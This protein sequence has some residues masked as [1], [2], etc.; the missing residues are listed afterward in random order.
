M[1][2][3]R[4]AGQPA[5]HRYRIAVLED[6]VDANDSTCMLL[7]MMG[8]DV[9]SAYDGIAGVELVE[10]LAPNVVLCD[11]GLPSLDGYGVIARL[12]AKMQ[13]PLP[14]MVALTGYDRQE[15]RVKTLAAGF[16]IHAVKP[17]DLDSLMQR[18]ARYFN[19]SLERRLQGVRA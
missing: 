8:N 7:Q 18:V 5:G 9:S 2:P 10:S 17:V 3:P 16:D 4:K 13:G 11:I 1:A 19:P 6:N 15:D 12:R 14:C